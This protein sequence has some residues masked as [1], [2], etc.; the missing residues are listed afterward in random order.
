VKYEVKVIEIN[1]IVASS[2]NPNQMNMTNF[3]RLFWHIAETGLYE[4][5]IVRPLKNRV[6]FF[7]LIN[8]YNRAK[9]LV[10]LGEKSINCVVWVVSD[11]QR[12]SYLLTLNRIAGKDDLEKKVDLLRRLAKEIRPATL[13]KYLLQTEDQ[14]K[15]MLDFE[16]KAAG[17]GKKNPL[18]SMVFFLKDGQKEKIEIAIKKVLE[19]FKKDV[20]KENK[21]AVAL[22]ALAEFYLE[23]S[24]K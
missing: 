9:A 19:S 22:T 5:V 16:I 6:G 20:P 18:N 8:G 3:L 24:S 21:R 14:I 11:L 2:D 7:Q 10:M 17:G 4:P 23:R 13:S 1:K 12:Y 15:K